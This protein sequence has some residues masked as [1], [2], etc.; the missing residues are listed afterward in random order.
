MKFFFVIFISFF[1]FFF[2][3]CNK[4]PVI[5]ITGD[6]NIRSQPNKDSEVLFIEKEGKVFAGP[7]ESVD[8]DW[9][10]IQINTENNS[11]TG[12]IHNSL[13]KEDIKYEVDTHSIVKIIILIFLLW[14]INKL[15]STRCPSCKKFFAKKKIDEKI[16]N[17]SMYTETVD[18]NKK[19]T[20]HL[21]SGRT[22]EKK[23]TGQRDVIRFHNTYRLYYMCKKC[24]HKWF[25]DITRNEK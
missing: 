23:I 11:K 8:N 14:C 24:G 1:S 4:I 16:I 2:Q 5:R 22:F 12:Y 25:I 18:D 17:Q 20:I 19:E 7:F 9:V 6:A 13:V 15:F 10:K 3:S 21:S